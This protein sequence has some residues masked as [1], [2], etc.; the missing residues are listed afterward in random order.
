MIN[1]TPK[2]CMGTCDIKQKNSMQ[3]VLKYDYEKV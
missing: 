1:T 3:H 2:S